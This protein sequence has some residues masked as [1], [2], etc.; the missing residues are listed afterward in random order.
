MQNYVGKGTVLELGLEIWS[1]RQWL[2][3]VVFALM[4]AG[5]AS[6]AAF[7]PNIYRSTVIVLVERHQVPETFV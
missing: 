4:L 5:T 6:V 1:R 3:V 2:A 7:L